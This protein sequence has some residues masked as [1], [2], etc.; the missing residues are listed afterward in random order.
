[1]LSE[2]NQTPADMPAPVAKLIDGATSERTLDDFAV[3][4]DAQEGVQIEGLDPGTAL[5]VRTRHSL[6]RLVIVD[7]PEDQVLIEGGRLFNEPTPARLNGATAGG[8]ALKMG[9]IAAGLRME[10]SVGSKRIRTSPVSS[11]EIEAEED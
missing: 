10:L 4:V 9:W 7:G 8:C 6:Y 2:I 3:Q 1:M 5:L 11:I